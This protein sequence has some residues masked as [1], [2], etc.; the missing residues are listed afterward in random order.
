[1][2]MGY[3]RLRFLQQE[4]Y[5]NKTFSSQGIRKLL[6]DCSLTLELVWM[7]KVGKTVG[8]WR[9]K[10]RISIIIRRVQIT[11]VKRAKFPWNVL[12]WFWIVLLQTLLSNNFKKNST[13]YSTYIFIKRILNFFYRIIILL[14]LYFYLCN[15]LL[16]KNKINSSI[17]I[18]IEK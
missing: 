8:V 6:R 12:D 2:H 1:M 13:F 5:L 14:K 9:W 18:L 4:E 16:L 17:L 15:H 11:K 10:H 7:M 3:S